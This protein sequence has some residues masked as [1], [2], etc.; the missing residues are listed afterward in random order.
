MSDRTPVAEAQ[1]LVWLLKDEAWAEVAHLPLREALRERLRRAE[2]SAE[3]L[4]LN[5]PVRD[6]RKRPLTESR[7]EK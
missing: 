6:P 5:V 2:K 7:S 3:A 1:L 4:G